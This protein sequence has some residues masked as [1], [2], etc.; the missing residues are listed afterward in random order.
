MNT[1]ELLDSLIN[2]AFTDGDEKTRLMLMSVR[3]SLTTERYEATE[4]LPQKTRLEEVL[5][6]TKNA[7]ERL[8]EERDSAHKSCLEASLL[9]EEYRA[10]SHDWQ[11][12]WLTTDAGFQT[13]T[14]QAAKLL[15]E[16]DEALCWKEKFEQ[17]E[18]DAKASEMILKQVCGERDALKEQLK[19]WD[20]YPPFE[21]LCGAEFEGLDSATDVVRDLKDERD[22]LKQSL[23]TARTIYAKFGQQ[24]NKAAAKRDALK[25]LIEGTLVPV[26]E[27]CV[28][29]P[30]APLTSEQ[31]AE[32]ILKA[33]GE[34]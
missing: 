18:A 1:N 28:P 31:L 17:A 6:V 14:A 34:A 27:M 2:R 23:E 21:E 33:K 3:D 24:R 9:V 15:T 8:T 13:I 4:L 25:T 26:L 32:T 30:Q 22:R 16:R 29:H 12:R 10:A 5:R 19:K 7:V 11:Q 20:T